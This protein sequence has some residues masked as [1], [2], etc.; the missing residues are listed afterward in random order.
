MPPHCC[1]ELNFNSLQHCCE[2]RIIGF[3]QTD[4][5]MA[6]QKRAAKTRSMT[7]GML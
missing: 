6:Q 1:K 7:R 3:Q 5:D 2:E 4:S